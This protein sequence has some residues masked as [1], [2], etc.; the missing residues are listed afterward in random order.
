MI[1]NYS[2]L[3]RVLVNI[4]KLIEK[5]YETN[6]VQKVKF[7][8]PGER[9]FNLKCLFGEHQYLYLRDLSFYC[10][11]TIMENRVLLIDY[12]YPCYG[13]GSIDIHITV[14][15]NAHKCKLRAPDRIGEVVQIIGEDGSN[16]T[17][18]LSCYN[19]REMG[20]KELPLDHRIEQVG[21]KQTVNRVRMMQMKDKEEEKSHRSGR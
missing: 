12:N 8:V 14:Y 3:N 13:D 5:S 4:G 6:E 11:A 21:Y 18:L 9:R 16:Y 10:F 2:F 15:P 7:R 17:G 20:V 1:V 19:C